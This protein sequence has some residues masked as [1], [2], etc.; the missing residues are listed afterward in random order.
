MFLGMMVGPPLMTVSIS[1]VSGSDSGPSATGS[2]ASSAGPTVTPLNG[3]GN[4]SYS[5]VHIS[6]SSGDTPSCNDEADQN[7]TWVATVADGTNSV[8]VWEV[9][10]HDLDTGQDETAQTTVTLI[11]A[12]TA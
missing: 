12:N 5:W 4:Y 7:P 6:T 3:S 9:T 2:V 10:V 11:W 8:S 1:A